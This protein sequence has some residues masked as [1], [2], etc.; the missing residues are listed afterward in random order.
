MFGKKIIKKHPRR[1]INLLLGLV[2]CLG[3]YNKVSKGSILVKLL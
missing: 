2:K 1:P 3:S